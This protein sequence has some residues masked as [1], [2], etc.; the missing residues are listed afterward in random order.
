M[1]IYE[2]YGLTETT[3]FSCINKFPKYNRVLGSIGK[4][5]IVNDMKIV[6]PKS[7]KEKNLMK[8]VKFVLED[9]MLLVITII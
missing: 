1:P 9:L 5:L 7:F 6:D 2:G 8:K 4:S 3:S